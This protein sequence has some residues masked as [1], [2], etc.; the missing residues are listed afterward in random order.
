VL[1]EIKVPEGQT[2]PI[3]TIVAVIDGAGRPRH[4]LR[5]PRQL[6]QRRHRGEARAGSRAC[7]SKP[8]APAQAPFPAAAP[9]ALLCQ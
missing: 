3:Q 2:V 1:K 6:L 5:Q 4:R 8:L 7:D 9:R